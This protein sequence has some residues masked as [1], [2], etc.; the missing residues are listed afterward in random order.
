MRDMEEVRKMCE[1]VMV[2]ECG[3]YE[4]TENP[5]NREGGKTV[6]FMSVE[7]VG[8]RDQGFRTRCLWEKM[9]MDDESVRE[10]TYLL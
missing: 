3:S 5:I 2:E 1:K 8:L 7:E 6:N 9:G 10:G 4:M